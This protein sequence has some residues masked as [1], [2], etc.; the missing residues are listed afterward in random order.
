VSAADGGTIRSLLNAEADPAFDT[1]AG[2]ITSGGATSAGPDTGAL[3][4]DGLDT[5]VRLAPAT[6]PGP[7]TAP[8][9]IHGVETATMA[10]AAS[11]SKAAL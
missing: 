6:A 8:G 7:L 9:P 5:G 3:L 1:S 2:P 11:A 4:L 10:N